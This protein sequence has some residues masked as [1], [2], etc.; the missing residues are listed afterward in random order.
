VLITQI[1]VTRT[2]GPRLILSGARTALADAQ[3]CLRM[4]TFI[5]CFSHRRK[6]P[7]K[8]LVPA[9]LLKEE[10]EVRQVSEECVFVL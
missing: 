8:T 3:K 4:R 10:A 9:C 1:F 2:G 6:K 7:V 5:L